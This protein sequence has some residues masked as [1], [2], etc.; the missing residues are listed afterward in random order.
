[1]RDI[2][3]HLDWFSRQPGLKPAMSGDGFHH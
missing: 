2:E 1:M 3:R